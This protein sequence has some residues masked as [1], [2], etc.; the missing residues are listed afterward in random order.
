MVHEGSILL[1]E[2]ATSGLPG[3]NCQTVWIFYCLH[4]DIAG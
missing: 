4:I 1:E 3:L 2:E